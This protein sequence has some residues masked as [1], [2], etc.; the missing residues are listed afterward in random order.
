[1]LAALPGVI[2]ADVNFS[3]EQNPGTV[4]GTVIDSGTTL[5]I[6]GILVEALI[7]TNVVAST[8]TDTLGTYT[9]S[10]LFPN[11]YTIR[12]S[13]GS[14][15]SQAKETSV[16]AGS[17]ITVDFAL[18][19]TRGS[20]VGQVLDSSTALPISGASVVVSQG[21]EAIASTQTDTNGQYKVRH[22]TPGQY[23]IHAGATP[24]QTAA[25]SGQITANAST[26]VNL[27]LHPAP[28]TL[29]GIVTDSLSNPISGANLTIRQNDI[30]VALATTST[31][32][33]YYVSGFSPGTYVT[34]ASAAGYR[35]KTLGFTA[36]AGQSVT[37]D[38]IMFPDPGSLGGTI[39]DAATA[40]PI[41]GATIDVLQGF[42]L[43]ASLT[44][45]DDGTYS[46]GGLPPATY[47]IR[48]SHESY[49]TAVQGAMIY[50][51]VQ[52]TSNFALHANPGT[53]EGTVSDIDTGQP[54]PGAY[55]NF[56]QG[57]T[58]LGTAV[59]DDN[60]GYSMSS[61]APGDY[62]VQALAEGYGTKTL[63]ATVTA[64]GTAQVSFALSKATGTI[65]GTVRDAQTANPIGGAII[66]LF[67]NS[68]VMTFSL[69]APDGT[70]T[71]TDVAPGTYL[72]RVRAAGYQ[73][74]FEGAIVPAD[75]TVE[76]D[77]SIRSTV[78]TISGNVSNTSSTPIAGASIQVLLG[79]QI[80][81]TVLTDMNGDYVVP[82]LAPGPYSMTV[83]AR[84]YQI[85]VAG[86]VA[87]ASNENFIMRAASPVPSVQG[88][89]YDV[90]SGAP[91]PG[92]LLEIMQNGVVITNCVADSGGAYT[93]S[94]LADGTYTI[95]ASANDYQTA[96]QGL[97][98]QSGTTATSNFYL[99]YDAGA[100]RGTITD[101]T[102]HNPI[103]EAIVQ[104][105]IGGKIAST[106]ITNSNG[107]YLFTDMTVGNYIINVTATGYQTTNQGAIVLNNQTAILNVALLPG[108]GT[109]EGYV[110]DAS[111]QGISGASIALMQANIII[112][113][114]TTDT[115]GHYTM[116]GLPPGSY[117]ARATASGYQIQTKGAFIYNNTTTSLDFTMS[118]NPSI[119]Q[120]TIYDSVSHNFIAGATV[121]ILQNPFLIVSTNSGSSGFYSV[122]G[123]A[124]GAYTIRVTQSGYQTGIADTY[125]VTPGSITVD[126][127]LEPNPGS[128]VG[129]V[130]SAATGNPVQGAFVYLQQNA[131]EIV[132]TFTDANGGYAF[133]NLLTGPS[134]IV[135]SASGYQQAIQGAY[136][137]SGETLTD[138][139]QL[140]PNPASVTGVVTDATT[141]NPLGGATVKLIQTSFYFAATQTD[142]QGRYSISGI[143]P[144]TYE[145]RANHSGFQ[146]HSENITFEAGQAE[147]VDFS[148][149]TPIGS[150]SGWVKDESSNP[151]PLTTVQALQNNNIALTVRTGLDG[152]YFMTGLAPGD[153]FLRATNLNFQI[154]VQNAT[155]TEGSITPANFT[156]IADPGMIT[157]IVT[158][159]YTGAVLPGVNIAAIQNNEIIIPCFSD[160]NGSYTLP[161]L[162]PGQ[163]TV[164]ATGPALYQIA[165]MTVNVLAGQTTIRNISLAREPGSVYGQVIDAVSKA[166]LVGIQVSAL[167]NSTIVA[168]TLTNTSGTYSI[169]GLAPGLYAIRASGQSTY[170]YQ[171]ATQTASIQSNLATETNFALQRSPGTLSGTVKDSGTK[172]PIPMAYI[173]V[174]NDDTVIASTHTNSL[175][176][177]TICGLPPG[178]Y[179]IKASRG[180]SYTSSKKTAIIVANQQTWVSFHLTSSP[181][182]PRHLKGF[183]KRRTHNHNYRKYKYTI[184][185]K[186]SCSPHI[187]GYYVYRDGKHIATIPKKDQLE[188]KDCHKHRKDHRYCVRA[189]N[190]S[191]LLST[192]VC[193]VLE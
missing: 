79:S 71:L 184:H 10:G 108:G 189:M 129:I 19:N 15:A 180:H 104:A 74:S 117:V 76:V 54:I 49:Q 59:S 53:I 144:N 167:S 153:Y 27:Q 67:Q 168:T 86:V 124:P 95:Q 98:V 166:R 164:I 99:I 126:L 65:I 158:D 26:T 62:V 112:Q 172:Q 163:Y 56:V 183:V 33:Q 131:V 114:G 118:S 100:L 37:E 45:Q 36:V 18:V 29:Q 70:Y 57:I 122:E 50:Q 128:V 66:G 110:T 44:S 101:A 161:S 23:I 82:D 39:V 25:V 6:E 171:V 186:P 134:T 139:F 21:A 115:N 102:T 13:N 17:T 85:Q 80:I 87:P 11:N 7:R 73:S 141:G 162:P 32:G 41:S 165:T 106:V 20:F 130:T 30:V 40:S 132:S 28:G 89:V 156:L 173:T 136:V 84:G 123:L 8:T 94:G 90:G 91:I 181:H 69:T 125:I 176:E 120:G 5:P 179:D 51:N 92:S 191:E 64:G 169:P 47:T 14:Y 174:Q 83:T 58:L 2:S 88:N 60:G 127:E 135:V 182:P 150:I 63:G 148:L 96:G 175:G 160:S 75:Q 77:F 193:I 192:R 151:L 31:N 38:F 152:L 147:T 121:D 185:W 12:V 119:I 143:A 137:V 9:L 3:L 116:S 4:R 140:L 22:L 35:S 97:V 133:N 145:L 78:A 42:I 48:V 157:G 149:N 154:G 72:V 111:A 16:S 155:V 55:V 52:T 170:Q 43:I 109:I 113:R 187:Q 103:A 46:I 93:I 159:A 105:S 177:Y 61:L 138:N 81:T 146:P 68:Q 190:S 34:T 188:Y 178:Q 1:M 107:Q 24:Y 142:D